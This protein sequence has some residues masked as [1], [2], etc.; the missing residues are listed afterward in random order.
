MT[1]YKPYE[2]MH[3]VFG[4]PE[5]GIADG[6]LFTSTGEREVY[7]TND[8]DTYTVLSFDG[9]EVGSG[10]SVAAALEAT[11]ADGWDFCR[12]LEAYDEQFS[13]VQDEDTW[14]PDYLREVTEDENILTDE[15][16]DIIS[17]CEQNA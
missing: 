6:Q 7:I 5:Q 13:A 12:W 16:E 10:T 4:E 11:G 17:A 14:D 9:E 8:G 2:A 15:L 3:A 1:D